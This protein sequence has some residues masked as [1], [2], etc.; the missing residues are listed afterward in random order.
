LPPAHAAW[1]CAGV[2]HVV[3]Q[4]PQWVGS[5]AV[6]TQ[7]EPQMAPVQLFPHFAGDV[8]VSQTASTPEQAAAAHDPQ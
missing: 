8:V 1:P 7:A 3:V 4:P 2:A 6:F 5:V